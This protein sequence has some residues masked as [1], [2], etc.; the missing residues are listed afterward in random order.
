MLALLLGGCATLSAPGQPP[1]RQAL[2]QFL[3]EGRF[4]LKIE[5][6]G[7]APGSASGRLSWRHEKGRDLLLLANPLG[8]GVAEL[9]IAMLARLTLA[10]GE[11][12]QSA[13]ADALL[14]QTTGYALPVSRLPG[15]LRGLAGP[16]GLLERDAQGRP[17]RLVEAG[18]SVVYGYDD[19]VPESP[20]AR[21]VV[22][23]PGEL[24][25]RLRLESWSVLP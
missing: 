8:G 7:E 20:P 18:W 5:R 1:A 10:N 22:T 2:E 12:R 14:L 19:A 17:A 11:V 23:R 6:V 9:E 21:L 24:E 25:L 4:A 3:V 15:W 16:D 13:D